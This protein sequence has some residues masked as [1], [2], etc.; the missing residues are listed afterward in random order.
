MDNDAIDKL[1]SVVLQLDLTADRL[2]QQLDRQGVPNQSAST[3]HINAGGITNAT[4]V[5]ASA[6][7]IILFMVLAVWTMVQL[8]NMQSEQRAWVG[9]MQQ[10]VSE[11][12]KAKE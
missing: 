12:R 2:S 11:A 9:V 8:S 3:V 5:V 6:T 4:A 10:Q 7:A 1:A